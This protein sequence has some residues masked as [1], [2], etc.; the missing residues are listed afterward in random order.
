MYS[1]FTTLRLST[2][3]ML[4]LIF[5]VGGDKVAV[6]VRRIRAV[7][8]R[9]KLSAVNGGPAWMAGVFVYRGR[10][11][12]VVDL[13]KLAGA[14]ECPPHLSSRIILLPWPP[15]AAESLIGLLATQVADVREVRPGVV[16]PIPGE[17]DR[18]GL[19]QALPDGNGILRLLD[20]DLLF[21]QVADG[22]GGMIAPGVRE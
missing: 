21:A 17:G 6:D 2:S 13:H 12:P 10:V 15:D 14:G 8:P 20:P 3:Q 11:V 16:Q 22:S 18:P 1:D 9:V 5:Q 4:A 7:V 19:G